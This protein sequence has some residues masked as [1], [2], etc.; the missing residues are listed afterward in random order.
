MNHMPDV[1][2]VNIPVA[3]LVPSELVLWLTEHER[4]GIVGVSVVGG[5][6]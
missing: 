5:P 2:S 3:T 4:C 6:V 1:A